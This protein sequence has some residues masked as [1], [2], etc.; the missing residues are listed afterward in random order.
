MGRKGGGR[1][2]FSRSAVWM[3]NRCKYKLKKLKFVPL[4]FLFAYLN[5]SYVLMGI[6]GESISTFIRGAKKRPRRASFQ[7]IRRRIP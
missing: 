2:F 1:V 7:L 6:G 5:A 3:L 4:I